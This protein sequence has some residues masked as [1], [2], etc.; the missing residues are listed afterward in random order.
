MVVQFKHISYMIILLLS[1]VGAACSDMSPGCGSDKA[2]D[3]VMRVVKSRTTHMHQI[4][5]ERVHTLRTNFAT[6]EVLCSA[7]VLITD[8]SARQKR[9]S[10]GYNVYYDAQRKLAI[11]VYGATP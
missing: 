2:V 1:V 9:V 8:S 10:V 6:G 3:E 11:D 7:A 5:V 4:K